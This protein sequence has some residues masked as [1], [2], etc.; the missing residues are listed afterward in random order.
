MKRDCTG[1]CQLG[2]YRGASH[3]ECCGVCY[4]DYSRDWQGASNGFGGGT[5]SDLAEDCEN[6]GL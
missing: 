2:P 1:D 5:L 3:W 4:E 6:V